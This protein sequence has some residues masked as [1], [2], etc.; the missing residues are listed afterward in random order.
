MPARQALEAICYVLRTGCPWKALPR[1]LGA[2]STVHERF[3]AWAADGVFERLGVAEL[4]EYAAL[5]G[6]AS[7]AR[8][9]ARARRSG[10]GRRGPPAM[11]VAQL[12]ATDPPIATEAGGRHAHDEELTPLGERRHGP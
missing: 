6:L 9:A 11:D 5:A 3:R 7:G 12:Q 4:P 8:T 10:R 1:G 2:P